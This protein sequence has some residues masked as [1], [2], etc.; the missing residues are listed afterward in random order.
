MTTVS[1]YPEGRQVKRVI[2]QL[3]LAVSNLGLSPAPASATQ[4]V[5]QLI[6]EAFEQLRPVENQT[7]LSLTVK[8]IQDANQLVSHAVELL[9]GGEGSGAQEHPSVSLDALVR[10]LTFLFP[11]TPKVSEA[12]PYLSQRPKASAAP[13][14]PSIKPDDRRHSPR[15]A[16]QIEV[17][18]D[19][20]SNFYTGFTSDISDGGLFV[21]TYSHKPVGERLEISFSLPGGHVVNAQ[22]V[23]RWVRELVEENEEHPPGMGIQFEALSEEDKAAIVEY[24]QR[25]SPLFYDD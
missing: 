10:A 9:R 12:P 22:G 6:Q 17:G 13:P 15:I 11:I 8:P 1:N 25:R 4:K 5:E 21:A 23:V 3:E 7:D 14:M 2:E 24:V 19:S 20:H 16:Y 18:F